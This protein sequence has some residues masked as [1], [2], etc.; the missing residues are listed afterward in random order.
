MAHS[1]WPLDDDTLRDAAAQARGEWRDD[2]EQATLDA[3]E[4]R[5]HARDFRDLL[6][7]AMARGDRIWVRCPGFRAAGVVVEVDDDLVSLRNPGGGRIDLRLDECPQLVLGLVD[8]AATD[9]C[10]PP[11]PSGGFRGRMLAIEA[12]GEEFSVSVRGDT[13]TLD[14]RILVGL[15]YLCVASRLGAETT[16]PFGQVVAVA[17]R[18]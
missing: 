4:V 10:T 6:R 18:G 14:G 13:D 9:G 8:A 17:P 12:T 11:L 16:V 3:V 5:R 1:T 2:Q 15:D 7:D